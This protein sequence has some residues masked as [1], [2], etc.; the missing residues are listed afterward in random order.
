MTRASEID[1]S[2][3]V[4]GLTVGELVRI[5]VE[6][7]A[8]SKPM[9]N[10]QEAADLTGFRERTIRDMARRRVIPF[11]KLENGSVRFS[12]EELVGWMSRNRVATDSEIRSL[13]REKSKRIIST[14]R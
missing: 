12:R 5:I 1:M 13:A 9:L 8:T 7:A 2:A 4:S 11:Y 14:I 6:A 3:P 10:T